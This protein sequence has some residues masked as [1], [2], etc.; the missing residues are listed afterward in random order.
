MCNNL[1]LVVLRCVVPLVEGNKVAFQQSNHQ[2]K[3][4]TIVEL[5]DNSTQSQVL[6]KG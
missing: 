6:V 3:V 2:D 4:D 1:L 5:H